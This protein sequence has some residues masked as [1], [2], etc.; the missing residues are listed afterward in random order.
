MTPGS[1]RWWFENRETGRITI[2]QPPNRP[3]A[4]AAGGWL[5]DLLFGGLIGSL[6]RWVSIGAL[7]YWSGDEIIRGVN[8]WRRVLGLTVLAW[9][10]IRI[11][12]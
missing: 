11:V 10:L 12:G 3:L 5:V 2:A 7:A 8:P 6:G 1:V 4:V 9:Q